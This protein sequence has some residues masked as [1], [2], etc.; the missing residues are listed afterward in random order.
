MNEIKENKKELLSPWKAL[1][2][3]SVSFFVPF[4]GYFYGRHYL[5]KK[6]EHLRMIGKIAI[7]LTT[8]SIFS[9]FITLFFAIK[10]AQEIYQT[11]LQSIPAQYDFL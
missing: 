6:D 9:T 8:I 7:I 5:K 2:I 1:A 4:S 11:T 3:F 10:I